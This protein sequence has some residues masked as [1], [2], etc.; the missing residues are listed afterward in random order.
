MWRHTDRLGGRGIPSNEFK[1]DVEES[2]TVIDER[3]ES[4]ARERDR[5]EGERYSERKRY[6]L[7]YSQLQDVN[8]NL[9]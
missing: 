4:V 5:G 2:C 3:S 1:M 6:C 7:W 8:I 9:R